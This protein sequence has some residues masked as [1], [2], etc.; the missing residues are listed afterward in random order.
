MHRSTWGPEKA[1]RFARWDAEAYKCY[2]SKEELEAMR[3][4]AL[5]VRAEEQDR[6]RAT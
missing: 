6:G 3:Q 2:C 1:G 5:I 4:E